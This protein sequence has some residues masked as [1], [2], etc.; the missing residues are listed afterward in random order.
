[1]ATN[2]KRY[3]FTFNHKRYNIFAN[4]DKEAGRLIAERQKALESEYKLARGDMLLKDWAEECIEAYKTNMSPQTKEKFKS[5]VRHSIS[6][7]IGDIRLKM[8]TPIDCQ[9]CL[10]LNAGKSKSLINSVYQALKFLFRYARL[11]HKIAIDPTENLIKPQGT[12]KK[13]RALTREER[14]AI[15]NVAPT[16]RSYWVYLLMMI[17]GCRPGEAAKAKM[18]DIS[19]V[20]DIKGRTYYVLHIRG[21]KTENADRKVPLPDWLYNL[22][23]DVPEDEHISLTRNGSV[24]GNN[25]YRHFNSFA[26][27]AGL[28]GDLSAY[29]LRHEFGTECA[30]R[31]LDMRI[32]MK[33]MGHATMRMTLEIY[34]NLE[35]ADVLDAALILN[36]VQ[37][38]VQPSLRLVEN[39]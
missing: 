14:Q 10:N 21:T 3:T 17:C 28:P 27:H 6:E 39:A 25:W 24:H 20:T 30:R 1:M 34:T 7:Q 36:D 9:N 33:L 19:R 26:K 31:G 16:N 11:N 18:S 15:L 8:I 23:K 37:P 12:K 5:L 29:N 38:P 2:K 4:S 13:R 35:S 32:T 22:F